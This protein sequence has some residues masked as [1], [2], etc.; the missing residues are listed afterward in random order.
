VYGERILREYLET[1]EIGRGWRRFLEESRPDV[2][3]WPAG[4]ALAALLRLDSDWQIAFEDEVAV[5]YERRK[6]ERRSGQSLP[7]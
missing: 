4:S 6:S 1:Q 7:E 5:V 3:V 2:V